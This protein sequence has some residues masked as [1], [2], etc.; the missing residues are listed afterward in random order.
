MRNF[1]VIGVDEN[2]VLIFQ[3]PFCF[4]ITNMETT[5]DGIEYDLRIGRIKDDKPRP[6]WMTDVDWIET[7]DEDLMAQADDIIE[8]ILSIPAPERNAE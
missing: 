5:E 1:E 2:A 8:Q 6:E 7:P 3:S 4:Y